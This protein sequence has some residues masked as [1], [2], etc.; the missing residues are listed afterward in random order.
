LNSKD[1][2]EKVFASKEAFKRFTVIDKIGQ[3]PYTSQGAR[4]MANKLANA[5]HV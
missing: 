4:I 1:A 2:I 3:T 5:P